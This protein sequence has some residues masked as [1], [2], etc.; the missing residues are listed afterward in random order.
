MC[1]HNVKP[2]ARRD[3][4]RLYLIDQATKYDHGNE[5]RY[6]RG[7]DHAIFI[8]KARTGVVVDYQTARN[9]LLALGKHEDMISGHDWANVRSERLWLCFDPVK[10]PSKLRFVEDEEKQPVAA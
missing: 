9:D 3:I 8:L 1:Y 6:I 2:E 10:H 4:L 5:N 7:V